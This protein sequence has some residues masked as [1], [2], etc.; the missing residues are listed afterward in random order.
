MSFRGAILIGVLFLVMVVTPV[1]AQEEGVKLSFTFAISE[2][3]VVQKSQELEKVKSAFDDTDG[4]GIFDKIYFDGQTIDV[5]VDVEDAQG[6]SFAD[7]TKIAFLPTRVRW[8]PKPGTYE[9]IGFL[10]KWGGGIN[11][12]VA[13]LIQQNENYETSEGVSVYVVNRSGVRVGSLFYAFMDKAV[14][15]YTPPYQRWMQTGHDFAI[16]TSPTVSNYMLMGKDLGLVDTVLILNMSLS[17]APAPS[18]QD[19]EIRKPEPGV[20]KESLA[21]PDVWNVFTGAGSSGLF[22]SVKLP[23]S[24]ASGTILVDKAVGMAY[25]DGRKI[26]FYPSTLNS[27]PSSPETGVNWEVLGFLHYFDDSSETNCLLSV[28]LGQAA[29]DATSQGTRVKIVDNTGMAVGR[30]GIAFFSSRAVKLM[31]SYHNWEESGND[32]A[33]GYQEGVSNVI[34]ITKDLGLIDKTMVIKFKLY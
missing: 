22:N 21:M 29:G 30:P 34:N 25:Q 1:S 10:H 32:F 11:Q 12:L 7:G 14:L 17:T 3:N 27:L 16:G 26:V 5:Q 31:G 13:I 19:F 6:F 9:A 28:L 2:G 4:D 23:D 20:V 8:L 24:T 15:R 33:I 18:G